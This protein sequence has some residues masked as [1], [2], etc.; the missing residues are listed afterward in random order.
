M[1][2]SYWNILLGGIFGIIRGII[3]ACF[4]LLIFSYISQKN[5][6]YYINHSILIN[7]F[8]ICTMFLLY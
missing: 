8:I 4:I 2:I 1:H 5:Y 7:R 6:N 3:L